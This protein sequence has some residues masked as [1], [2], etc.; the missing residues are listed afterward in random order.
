MILLVFPP[1]IIRHFLGQWNYIANMEVA[2]IGIGVGGHNG[3][4][5]AIGGKAGDHAELANE[6]LNLVEYYN[7]DTDSW[8]RVADINF[9]RANAKVVSFNGSL[10]VLG[11]YGARG[12]ILD[13]VEVYC[14]QSDTWTVVTDPGY[15]ISSIVGKIDI[16]SKC[17]VTL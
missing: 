7:P 2:R 5:Y 1:F 17:D 13:S 14:P 11:G 6:Y 16:I 8:T 15:K 12:Q 10:H 3:L 9:P 4:L